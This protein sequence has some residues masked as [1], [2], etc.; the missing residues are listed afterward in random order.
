MT[1]KQRIEFNKLHKRLRRE[2][3][4]AIA[5]FAMI[6]P[7]DKVMACLSGGK[8]SYTMLDILLHLRD[9]APIDFEVV[10]VNLD[11]K[12]PNFPAHVLPGYLDQLGDRKSVV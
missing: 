12:Q 10:A 9:S 11:Q 6:E 4:Q 1:P 5:D 3:G 8:D 7:G 2:V